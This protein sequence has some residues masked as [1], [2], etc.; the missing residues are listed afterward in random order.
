MGRKGSVLATVK[1]GDRIEAEGMKVEIMYT[2]QLVDCAGI[3]QCT[4]KMDSMRDEVKGCFGDSCSSWGLG[5]G[6]W[7]LE[8]WSFS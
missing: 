5:W 3:Q 4:W 8:L 6:M 2:G 7:A 1:S